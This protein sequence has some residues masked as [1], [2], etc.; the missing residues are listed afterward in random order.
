MKWCVNGQN[1]LEGDASLP[2]RHWE[3]YRQRLLGLSRQHCLHTETQSFFLLSFYKQIFW[4]RICTKAFPLRR[5]P[6]STPETKMS[7]GDSLNIF[8]VESWLLA[9]EMPEGINKYD[10]CRRPE[11]DVTSRGKSSGIHRVLG[12]GSRY[13]KCFMANSMET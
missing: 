3:T 2:G 11:S 12:A 6:S 8:S 7:E 4:I 1:L 10:S 13:I 5:N 9:R